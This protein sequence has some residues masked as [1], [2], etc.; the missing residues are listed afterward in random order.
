MGRELRRKQAKREG[1]SLKK[2]IV[3]EENQMKKLIKI[4]LQLW[5]RKARKITRCLGPIRLPMACCCCV[6][7]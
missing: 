4:T 5:Q 2:E 6:S 1:K 3:A 7:F